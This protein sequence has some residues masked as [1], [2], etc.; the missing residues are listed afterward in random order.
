MN[1]MLFFFLFI[2]FLTFSPI[3]DIRYERMWEKNIKGS[4]HLTNIMI[5]AF[6]FYKSQS[7]FSVAKKEKKIILN[8]L[9]PFF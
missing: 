5:T 9:N 8:L 1:G 2:Y 7:F 3:K 4:E 6:S